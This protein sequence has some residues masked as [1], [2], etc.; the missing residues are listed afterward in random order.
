MDLTL[1][2][3]TSW[4]DL[5][6]LFKATCKQ[7][8]SAVIE[9]SNGL[10]AQRLWVACYE[11]LTFAA[12]VAKLQEF[13]LYD[14]DAA[15]RFWEMFGQTREFEASIILVDFRANEITL[16]VDAD[17]SNSYRVASAMLGAVRR[18]RDNQEKSVNFWQRRV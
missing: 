7:W 2:G 10:A 12:H 13:V 16:T 3:R 11:Q 5:D 15:F 6:S 17:G 4:T 8:P 14:S 1:V 18:H 9:S